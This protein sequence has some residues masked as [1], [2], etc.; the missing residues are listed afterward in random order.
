M[1]NDEGIKKGRNLKRFILL[2]S[3]IP[4][5]ELFYYHLFPK[6]NE[7]YYI[8]PRMPESA[9]MVKESS[10]KD[11]GLA[12]LLSDFQTHLTGTSRPKI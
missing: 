2:I 1:P 6:L 7:N 4:L 11:P 12:V 10:V 8:L 9:M 3:Q 5:I